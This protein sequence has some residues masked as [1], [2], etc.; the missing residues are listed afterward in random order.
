[1]NEPEILDL[2]KYKETKEWKDFVAYVD[3]IL[4]EVEGKQQ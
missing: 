3:S 1:M 2:A 4:R